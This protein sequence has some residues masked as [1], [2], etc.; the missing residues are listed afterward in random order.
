MPTPLGLG[1][2]GRR[3]CS[4]IS[5]L[6]LCVCENE[7]RVG[8]RVLVLSFGAST[9]ECRADALL[10]VH[11]ARYARQRRLVPASAFEGSIERRVVV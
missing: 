1:C 10:W 2:G 3:L 4:G 11:G 6:C 5:W 7:G 9:R 8:V